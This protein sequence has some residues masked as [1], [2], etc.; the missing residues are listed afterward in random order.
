MTQIPESIKSLL[1]E[2]SNR[3][4]ITSSNDTID[5]F[6][7]FISDYPPVECKL[8]HKFTKGLYSREIFMPAGS[9]ITSRIHKTQ[10]QFAIIEGEVSVWTK[11]TGM[12]RYKAPYIGITEPGTR[13][14]LF[15]HT[16]VRWITFHPT[17]LTTVEEI[18]KAILEPHTNKL[19]E[20]KLCLG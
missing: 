12:V 5:L 7:K 13:R 18:E 2:L 15:N 4:V 14:V 8:N 6:E 17:D 11:E 1:I 20:G 3:S 9:V 10:H 16:D 19:L